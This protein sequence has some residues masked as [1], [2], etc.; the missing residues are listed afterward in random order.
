MLLNGSNKPNPPSIITDDSIFVRVANAVVAAVHRWPDISV[1]YSS[2]EP[3]LRRA[4]RLDDGEISSYA[5]NGLSDSPANDLAQFLGDS[6]PKA[7]PSTRIAIAVTLG[8][9]CSNGD[10]S[11]RRVLMQLQGALAEWFKTQAAMTEKI[12]NLCPQRP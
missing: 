10:E 6:F 12:R 5:V 9:R 2:V 3:R 1:D 4:A 8:T 11:A 7:P